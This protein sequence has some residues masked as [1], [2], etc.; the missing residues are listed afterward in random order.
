[1]RIDLVTVVHPQDGQLRLEL[2]LHTSPPQVV[3]LGVIMREH[4]NRSKTYDGDKKALIDALRSEASRL[5]AG[6]S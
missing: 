4:L 6:L 3:R 1:M 2:L 5:D